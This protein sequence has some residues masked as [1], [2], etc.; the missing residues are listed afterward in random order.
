[1]RPTS[2]HDGFVDGPAGQSHLYLILG[3]KVGRNGVK[4]LIN[5]EHLVGFGKILHRKGGS[6]GF[7]GGDGEEA[8][9]KANAVR[10]HL[11]IKS[12]KDHCNA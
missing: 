4:E 3:R 5:V 8:T 11:T 10:M 7:Q 9:T 2:V 6:Q 1:M 12:P